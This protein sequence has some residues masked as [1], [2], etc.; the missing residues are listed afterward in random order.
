[1]ERKGITQKDLANALIRTPATMCNKL[2]GNAQLT[3]A[4]AFAIQKLIGTRLSIDSLFKE[5]E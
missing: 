4:E 2:S 3:L 1:M 5:A